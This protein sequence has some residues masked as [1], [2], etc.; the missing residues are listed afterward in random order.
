MQ[1]KK[2]VSLEGLHI[3]MR[4]V[5][6]HVENVYKSHGKEAV[7]TSGTEG[8]FLDGVHGMNSYHYFGM[9]LDFRTRFFTNS[10]CLMV[11]AELK[12]LLGYQY[13][14][15]FEVNHIHIQY[16]WGKF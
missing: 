1:V 16:N 13:T 5:R 4:I 15:I 10:T 6:A 3:S 9:A 2:G 11:V 12:R 8:H 14:V 7:I